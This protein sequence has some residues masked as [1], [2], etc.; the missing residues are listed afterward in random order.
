MTPWLASQPPGLRLSGL[1]LS[2]VGTSA[3]F[4]PLHILILCRRRRN[5]PRE[6]D[7]VP[8]DCEW[9]NYLEHRRQWLEEIGHRYSIG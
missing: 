1:G 5:S 4:S 6:W 3:L 8:V 7:V 9:Y 2:M